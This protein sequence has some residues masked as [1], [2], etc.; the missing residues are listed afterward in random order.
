M[1]SNGHA[2]MDVIDE[3]PDRCDREFRLLLDQLR[4]G[5]HWREIR[6]REGWRDQGGRLH[7]IEFVDWPVIANL[8]DRHAP[9][10]SYAIQSVIPIGEFV[11]AT[12]AITIH[13]VTR[14]GL[15]IGRVDSTT[16][17]L[18]AENEALKRAAARFGVARNLYLNEERIP[19]T[20]S[21]DEEEPELLPITFDPLPKTKGEMISLKQLSLIKA[22]GKR[23][24]MDPESICEAT[25][26]VKLI[27][28][29]RRAASTLI[30]HMQTFVPPMPEQ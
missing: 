8:L 10:W 16:G 13:G 20:E 26:H 30:Q 5:I 11:I 19:Q 14:E 7:Y 28:I 9:E 12:A 21:E 25:F 4:R 23:A 15:G 27:E 29:S 22:L 17:I 6:K 3:L 24:Q 18:K 2:P 1:N